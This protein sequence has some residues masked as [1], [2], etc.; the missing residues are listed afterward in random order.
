VWENLRQAE[1]ERGGRLR[2]R[3]GF[4]CVNLDLSWAATDMVGIDAGAI[5]LALDNGLM[6]DRVR[7][8]F[9]RIPGVQRGLKRLGCTPVVAPLRAVA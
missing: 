3:Y 8:T 7:E 9:H 5:G 1:T 6:A 2:G 4:S